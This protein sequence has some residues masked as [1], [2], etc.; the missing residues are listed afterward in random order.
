MLICV[1]EISDGL[2]CLRKTLPLLLSVSLVQIGP[3][4]FTLSSSSIYRDWGLLTIAGR[5][6]IMTWR[7]LKTMETFS[8]CTAVVA[9]HVTLLLILMYSGTCTPLTAAPWGIQHPYLHTQ[10]DLQNAHNSLPLVGYVNYLAFKLSLIPPFSHSAVHKFNMD[11]YKLYAISTTNFF[12]RYPVN[13]LC[14]F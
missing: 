9:Y 10:L 7:I 11:G 6:E 14:V 8:K 3:S 4:R 1:L 13:R 12:K 5:C 2:L